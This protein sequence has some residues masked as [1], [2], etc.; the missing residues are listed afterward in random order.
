M[1]SKRDLR[2]VEKGKLLKITLNQS[3]TILEAIIE[4]QIKEKQAEEDRD[5]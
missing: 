2:S 4:E 3:Q 5:K 1:L